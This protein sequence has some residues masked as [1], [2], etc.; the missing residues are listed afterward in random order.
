MNTDKIKKPEQRTALRG[1]MSAGPAMR[2][3]RL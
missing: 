3:P 2:D 1:A